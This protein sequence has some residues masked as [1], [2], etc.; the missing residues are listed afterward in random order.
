MKKEKL[1]AS[2]NNLSKV[3]LAEVGFENRF[4]RFILRDRTGFIPVIMYRFR[5]CLASKQSTNLRG[6]NHIRDL[7]KKDYEG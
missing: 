4:T 5:S 6:F 1:R 2:S 3:I 7:D